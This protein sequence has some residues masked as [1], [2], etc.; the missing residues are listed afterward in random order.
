[1]D[2]LA[3]KAGYLRSGVMHVFP[4][5]EANPEPCERLAALVGKDTFGLIVRSDM[6]FLHV[7]T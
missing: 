4:H 3:T 5:D 6:L 7:F 1:M 2:S